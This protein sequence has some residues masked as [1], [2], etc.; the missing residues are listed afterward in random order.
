[1]F[2]N[3]TNKTRYEDLEIIFGETVN[4]KK[5]SF[6]MNIL[7]DNICKH[8]KHNRYASHELVYNICAINEID[9]R[10]HYE[11]YS[12]PNQLVA[13]YELACPKERYVHSEIRD[14]A[15]HY[16][17]HASQ[18]NDYISSNMSGNNLY[19]SK[20]K[21]LLELVSIYSNQHFNVDSIE[22]FKQQLI[23]LIFCVFD[24]KSNVL[25]IPNWNKASRVTYCCD[26]YISRLDELFT[27]SQL[28]KL[29]EL[30]S[31]EEP[32]RHTPAPHRPTSYPTPAYPDSTTR[33]PSRVAIDSSYDDEHEVGIRTLG[34]RTA[35]GMSSTIAPSGRHE[36]DDIPHLL[37][38]STTKGE[39]PWSMEP[40][41]TS[42]HDSKSLIDHSIL[43][44]DTLIRDVKVDFRHTK[45]PTEP[46]DSV[47]SL[48]GGP[49]RSGRDTHSRLDI[50]RRSEVKPVL[51]PAERQKIVSARNKHT[52]FVA[53]R[54]IEDS[55][56]IRKGNEY[57]RDNTM[58]GGGGADLMCHFAILFPFIL[59]YPFT[60]TYNPNT[61]FS[62]KITSALLHKLLEDTNKINVT[63]SSFFN[64]SEDTNKCQY[65]RL[66]DDISKLWMIDPTTNELVD[67]SLSSEY[68]KT[69][70]G[71]N[72]EQL[73]KKLGYD[74][75]ATCT[76][77]LTDCITNNND[78][79]IKKCK[80]YMIK[81][82]Y[83][84]KVKSEIEDINPVL[85]KITLEK[86]GFKLITETDENSQQLLK[87]FESYTSW[88]KNLYELSQDGSNSLESIE[89]ENIS[90]NVQLKG[91]LELLVNKINSN[92]SILN[93]NFVCKSQSVY[94]QNTN[95]FKDTR[96]YAYGIQ[97]IN[98]NRYN[99]TNI[100]R[101][102]TLVKNKTSRFIDLLSL[103][104]NKNPFH[105]VNT[106]Y[107]GMIGGGNDTD[108]ILTE[109][110]PSHETLHDIFN[111]LYKHLKSKN[112]TIIPGDL[113]AIQSE[114]DTLRKS[115]SKLIK[116]ISYLEKYIDITNTYK[117][118]DPDN[119]LTVDH[120]VAFA[121]KTK[122]T[123]NILTQSQTKLFNLLETIAKKL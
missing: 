105:Y 98:S 83:W 9:S 3:N 122:H 29:N 87:K 30:I 66:T 11:Y 33:T 95:Q 8:K 90:S 72:E 55:A 7:Y 50:L 54:N 99:D 63:V 12:K 104:L 23:N 45:N 39:K 93:P 38:K 16:N 41:D 49:K 56:Q 52:A 61:L 88:I 112:K 114:L 40:L 37:Y 101:V 15:Y 21:K 19:D 64:E 59:P 53:K 91:Y 111:G 75:N 71:N 109:F 22:Y 123:T 2:K 32:R 78:N 115:E 57:L 76:Q 77:Y 120:I 100:E 74:D 25:E 89:Y 92:P 62:F 65:F 84:S 1:M 44:R 5:A 24:E 82:D 6:I 13:E 18:F 36:D 80:K 96:L 35:T 68:T 107:I 86:F 113:T 4:N 110:Q 116:L 73:C 27:S 42:D 51:T 34:S 48:I 81:P 17:I 46:R 31:K 43:G 97:S 85:G 28:E 117:Q 20:H 103:L 67:I 26:K 108:T 47:S 69:Y 106:G 10:L 79:D 121:D 102:I 119:V 70:L 118:N 60:T 94:N 14:F 58:Y